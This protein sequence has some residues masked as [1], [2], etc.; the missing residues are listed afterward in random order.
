ML[1]S[2][3]KND[4]MKYMLCS[5][6]ILLLIHHSTA[7]CPNYKSGD[8]S[9]FGKTK[10]HRTCSKSFQLN[11]VPTPEESAQAFT[12][13]IVKSHEDRL[14]ALKTLEDLKNSE[15]QALKETLDSGTKQA[16][17]SIK[18]AKQPGT[19]P[20]TTALEMSQ[21]IESYQNFMA[22]YVVKAQED[23]ARAVKEA[24]VAAIKK[25][26]EK[27][28]TL[29]AASTSRTVERSEDSKSTSDEKDK[30]DTEIEAK[31]SVPETKDKTEDETEAIS[32]P[33]PKTEEIEEFQATMNKVDIEISNDIP[34]CPS[35]QT[36]NEVEDVD[37]DMKKVKTDEKTGSNE[38]EI[39]VAIAVDIESGDL[40]NAISA[41]ASASNS[42]STEEESTE[43]DPEDPHVVAG[44]FLTALSI[45]VALAGVVEPSSLQ[46][47]MHTVFMMKMAT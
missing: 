23:K 35:E 25:Y 2:L 47:F 37:A 28:T 20:D 32:S 6:S 33:D 46:N 30:M 43:S 44:K 12:N 34:T 26:E 14:K 42:T 8:Y 17:N 21:K 19:V 22:E 38:T 40:K 15:I 7:F 36:I 16:Q 1:C 11:A 10:S 3:A 45:S 4:N 27:L 41:S 24:E 29:Q 9:S 31:N 39:T 18:E 13:Y 5:L